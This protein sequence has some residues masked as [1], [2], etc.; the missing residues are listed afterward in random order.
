[1]FHTNDDLVGHRVMIDTGYGETEL[2]TV[3]AVSDKTCNIK[4]RTDDGE[5]LVG[6]QWDNA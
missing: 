6:S 5:I 4:V 2:A 1:M 3:I